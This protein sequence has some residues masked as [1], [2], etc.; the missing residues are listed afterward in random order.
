MITLAHFFFGLGAVLGVGGFVMC[1]I[2]LSRERH[3]TP[4]SFEP[5]SLSA[6]AKARRPTP[7]AQQRESGLIFTRNH[8]P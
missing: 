6:S 5:E 2:L 4:P 3:R 1:A 7:G 8:N